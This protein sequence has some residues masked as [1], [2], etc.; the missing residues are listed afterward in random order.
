M[1]WGAV[2]SFP[3]GPLGVPGPMMR[4]MI[5]I[6]GTHVVLRGRLSTFDLL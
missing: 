3:P 6:A 5:G 4:Q 1:L 2:V